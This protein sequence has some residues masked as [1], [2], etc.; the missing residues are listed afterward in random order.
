MMMAA[1]TAVGRYWMGAVRNSRIKP[2]V[3]ALI[4]PPTWLVTRMESLTAVR[5]PLA[6]IGMPEVKPAATFEIPK[7]SS[8]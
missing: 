1:R 7:A 8:S 2:T 6:P 4:S 5:E 3:T